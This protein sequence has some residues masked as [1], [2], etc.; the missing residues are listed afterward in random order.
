MYDKILELTKF[1]KEKNETI[2][3]MLNGMLEKMAR[4][5][6]RKIYLSIDPDEMEGI[7]NPEKVSEETSVGLVLVDDQ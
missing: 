6:S 3:T 7:V 4:N 2:Y 1:A 5:K